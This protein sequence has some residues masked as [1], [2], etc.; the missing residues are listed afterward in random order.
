MPSVSGATTPRRPATAPAI[1]PR[2]T[3]APRPARSTSFV[4]PFWRIGT[5]RG[6]HPAAAPQRRPRTAKPRSSR[7]SPHRAGEAGRSRSPPRNVRSTTA[8]ATAA[9]SEPPRTPREAAPRISSSAKTTPVIG[10]L[11]IAAI[12]AAVPIG[13]IP[14]TM[15]P[16][17]PRAR[18]ARTAN[19]L[20]RT[21][22]GPSGPRGVPAPS[23]R[24]FAP[25]A[26]TSVR[27]SR[28]V[29]GS[30]A[31]ALRTR[32]SPPRRAAPGGERARPGGPRPRRGR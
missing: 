32:A 6:S 10:A 7:R 30:P 31:Y 11:K 18:A 15:R 23:E 9:R 3:N 19:P 21:T 20:V 17:S 25:N 26:P 2:A 16:G 28:R 4:R 29:E 13:T 12:P 22:V 14:R 1:A 27:P 24:A 5:T 8:A